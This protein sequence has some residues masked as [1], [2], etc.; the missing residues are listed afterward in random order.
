MFLGNLQGGGRGRPV[1]QLWLPVAPPPPSREGLAL[2]PLAKDPG[3]QNQ[4]KGK[5][6]V[7]L[8][9]FS[10]TLFKNKALSDLAVVTCCAV[11]YG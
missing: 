7:K 5:S 9:F 4:S 6:G 11:S 8:I 3:G 1:H 10:F 2:P